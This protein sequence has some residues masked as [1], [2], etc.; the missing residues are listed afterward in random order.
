MQK[1]RGEFAEPLAGPPRRIITIEDKY[2][3]VQFWEKLKSEQEASRRKQ[4]EAEH[5]A[6]EQGE[7]RTRRKKRTT[8]KQVQRLNLQKACLEKY[9]DIVGKTQVCKWVAACGRESWA[10]I[11]PAVRQRLTVINNTLREQKGLPLKGRK[12]GGAV[13]VELQVEL[14]R[15]IAEMC[16]GQSEVTSR[17]QIVN[18]DDIAPCQI[19]D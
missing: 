15:L 7:K 10:E 8:K 3:V 9:P 17:Q 14:D 12:E 13:P 16:Q 19:A 18:L 1:D 6:V 2:K 4:G 5:H 11:P